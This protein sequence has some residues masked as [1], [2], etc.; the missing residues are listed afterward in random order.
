MS[1]QVRLGKDWF[2]S[3]HLE[4]SAVVLCEVISACRSFSFA[5][6]LIAAREYSFRRWAAQ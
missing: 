1:S 2:F 3:L 4:T 6:A 5:E